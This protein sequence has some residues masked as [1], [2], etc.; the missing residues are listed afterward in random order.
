LQ[1]LVAKEFM[2]KE[3][4]KMTTDIHSRDLEKSHSRRKMKKEDAKANGKKMS[5]K[6]IDQEIAKLKEQ[7]NALRRILEEDRRLGWILR[8]KPVKWHEMQ[9][10]LQQMQVQWLMEKLKEVE[11]EMEDYICEP[12]QIEILGESED[13]DLKTETSSEARGS[14]G[15]KSENVCMFTSKTSKERQFVDIVIKKEEDKQNLNYVL[16]EDEIDG[17]HMQLG[18]DIKQP[19]EGL[20]EI[21]EETIEEFLNHMKDLEQVKPHSLIFLKLIVCV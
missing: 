13:E 5:Q 11:L 9:R 3:E 21:E 17:S 4:K 7:L 12:E 15:F 20:E 16:E 10:R 19:S 8:K 18:K 6:E 14:H 1:R 2:N